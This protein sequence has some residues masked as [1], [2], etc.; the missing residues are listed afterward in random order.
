MIFGATML[1]V[2]EVSY[3]GNISQNLSNEKFQANL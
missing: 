2:Y 1:I 3:V